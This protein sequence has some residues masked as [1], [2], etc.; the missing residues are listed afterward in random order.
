M[1]N[2]CENVLR[3]YGDKRQVRGL[4]SHVR[5]RDHEGRPLLFSLNSVIPMPADEEDWHNWCVRNWTTKWEL[6]PDDISCLLIEG[7]VEYRMMTAWGPPLAVAGELAR[8]HPEVIIEWAYCEPGME[9]FGLVSYADGEM[10]SD[11][12]FDTQQRRIDFCVKYGG[13]GWLSYLALPEESQ[14]P[15]PVRT[16]C[17]RIVRSTGKACLLQAPH[18]PP[19][20]S[21]L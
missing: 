9:V 15:P 14:P 3:V 8:Q 16:S 17:G 19:C 21:K 12:E 13:S 2:W 20:R 4:M 6:S 1:P 5:G 7:G 11:D 10:R 18:K